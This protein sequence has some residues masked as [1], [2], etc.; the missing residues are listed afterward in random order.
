MADLA[1]QRY[2][3]DLEPGMWHE[4]TRT[5]TQE[6]VNAFADLTGDHNPIHLDEDYAKGTMFKTRIAH[7]AFVAS[8]LSGV[9]GT[10]LP[11]PGAI[12]RSL[13]LNYR[14]PVRVGDT[15]LARVEV[16]EVNPAKN[17]VKLKVS[18]AVNGLKVVRGEA[19]A[20][21]ANRPA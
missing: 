19:M 9:M 12:F 4:I 21:V 20:W 11:G 14:A 10:Q 6:Q 7:G 15:I 17:M 13:N 2:V 16:E 3:E 8:F 18:C 5:I 1:P